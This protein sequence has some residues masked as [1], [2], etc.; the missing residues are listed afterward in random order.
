M[1]RT[2]VP[3]VSA[4]STIFEAWLQSIP[5]PTRRE[6]EPS[7]S[8]A[9]SLIGRSQRRRSVDLRERRRLRKLRDDVV[10]R[11][12]DGILDPVEPGARAADGAAVE[13]EQA[14]VRHALEAE[15]ADPVDE[16]EAPREQVLRVVRVAAE[17]N[18]ENEH[19]AWRE[20]VAHPLD[21]GERLGDVLEH[22]EAYDR[23]E[24][25][26]GRVTLLE[27]DELELDPAPRRPR[28]R[29]RAVVSRHVSGGDRQAVA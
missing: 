12:Q 24:R 6:S 16:P 22:V 20:P 21:G 4:T 28:R 10:G 18:V 14:R 19:A 3:N 8:G 13:D 7:G 11:G 25:A 26:A 1:T 17:C 5:A 15:P 23:V 29:E 27:R 9:S 2:A